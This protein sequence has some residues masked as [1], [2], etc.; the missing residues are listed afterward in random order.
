MTP[1][2]YYIIALITLLIGFAVGCIAS[3]VSWEHVLEYKAEAK[4][5]IIIGKNSYEIRKKKGN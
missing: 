1:V 2:E 3:N 5:D 4:I